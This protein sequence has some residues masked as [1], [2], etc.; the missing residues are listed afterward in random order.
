MFLTFYWA[1]NHIWTLKKFSNSLE[2]VEILLSNSCSIQLLTKSLRDIE[3]EI[4]MISIELQKII[5]NGLLLRPVKINFCLHPKIILSQ[6]L[7]SPVEATHNTIDN[8]YL[9][10]KFP[11]LIHAQDLSHHS[12]YII[13]SSSA[14]WSVGSL[15]TRAC[16]PNLFTWLATYLIFTEI[17]T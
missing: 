2:E 15:G 1:T 16:V 17:N 9:Y 3:T 5:E 11:E 7:P 4:P 13:V 14:V 8:S 12:H 6:K 10:R